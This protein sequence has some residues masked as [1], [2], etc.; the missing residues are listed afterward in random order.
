MGSESKLAAVTYDLTSHNE[1]A[2][3]SQR[4]GLGPRKLAENGKL[5]GLQ[6]LSNTVNMRTEEQ[7]PSVL[8][9]KYVSVLQLLLLTTSYLTLP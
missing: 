1:L 5:L 7:V 2:L 4:K 8:E 3:T 6:V 9:Y